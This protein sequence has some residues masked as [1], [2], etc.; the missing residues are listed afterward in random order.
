MFGGYDSK[1]IVY[2][3]CNLNIDVGYILKFCILSCMCWKMN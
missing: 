2:F 1:F 3:I